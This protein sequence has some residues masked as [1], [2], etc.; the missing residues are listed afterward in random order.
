V[1]YGV[2][3]PEKIGNILVNCRIRRDYCA[4]KLNQI[5]VDRPNIRRRKIKFRT[6]GF[7]I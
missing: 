6:D 5:M 1:C 7:K 2:N 3:L 4:K